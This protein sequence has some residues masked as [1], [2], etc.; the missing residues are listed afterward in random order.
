MHQGQNFRYVQFETAS[1]TGYACVNFEWRKEADRIDYT[2]GISFCSPNDKFEKSI[3]RTISERRRTLT[4]RKKSI[5]ASIA[6]QD[7]G[8]KYVSNKEFDSVLEDILDRAEDKN[9]VPKWA[10]K[11]YNN[12]QFRFGLYQK[13]NQN[14][15]AISVG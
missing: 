12:G 5:Q 7:S 9:L 6:V 1:G 8:T 3:A 13:D 14:I 4:A 11:A 10:W 2:A 15:S